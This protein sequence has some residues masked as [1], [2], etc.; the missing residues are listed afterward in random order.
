MAFMA[1]ASGLQEPT[2]QNA[3]NQ[4]DGP[5]QICL[6]IHF[7]AIYWGENQSSK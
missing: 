6:Y 1:F 2:Y 3:H 7:S 5:G 4:C